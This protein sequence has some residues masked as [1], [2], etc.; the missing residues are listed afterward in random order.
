MVILPNSEVLYSTRVDLTWASR[1]KNFGMPSLPSPACPS[2][3]AMATAARR[4]V[5]EYVCYVSRSLRSSNVRRAGQVPRRKRDTN[6][7]AMAPPL[8]LD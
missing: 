1:V 7:S 5:M 8:L 3:R 2:V 6:I 4:L